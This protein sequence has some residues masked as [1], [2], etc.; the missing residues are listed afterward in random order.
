ME[1]Y[2]WTEAYISANSKHFSFKLMFL[3]AVL[4]IFHEM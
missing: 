1:L 4:F 3:E 2:F